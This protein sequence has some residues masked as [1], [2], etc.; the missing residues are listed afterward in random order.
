MKDADPQTELEKT[1]GRFHEINILLNS[2][3]QDV[4]FCAQNSTAMTQELMEKLQQIYNDSIER[5]TAEG[6]DLSKQLQLLEKAALSEM[7]RVENNSNKQAFKYHESLL[8]ASKQL[9]EKCQSIEN[10]LTKQEE[11]LKQ[12]IEL[13]LTDSMKK[14]NEVISRLHASIES[15]GKKTTEQ[16]AKLAGLMNQT[17]AQLGLYE[18]AA[19]SR[20]D[21]QTKLL[22]KSQRKWMIALILLIILGYFV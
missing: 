1:V 18:N 7:A 17:M 12:G 10:Q 2:N 5:L 9:I 15:H 21:E 11:Q 16:Q 19:K 13:V 4:L 6:K 22:R 8:E 20:A 3:M 14:H